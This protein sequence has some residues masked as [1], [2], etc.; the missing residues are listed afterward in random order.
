MRCQDGTGNANPDDFVITFS[1]SV[2]V[3]SI[4]VTPTSVTGGTQATATRA[5][6]N[7]TA[8]SGGAV[9]ISPRAS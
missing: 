6:L 1:V 4:S 5:T 7:G 9:V 2:G 3:S 8:L